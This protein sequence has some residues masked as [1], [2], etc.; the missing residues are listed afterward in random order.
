MDLEL[1]P[2]DVAFRDEVRQFIAD[3]L[4][5]DIRQKMRLG[6]RIEKDDYVRWQKIL[7]KRGWM[8]VGWPVEHG[9][10]NRKSVV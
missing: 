2:E 5:D 7:H 10:P 1:S 8:G 3:N 4:P 6:Q 9:G